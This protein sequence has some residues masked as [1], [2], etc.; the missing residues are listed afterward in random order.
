MTV[1]T[2]LDDSSSW[3]KNCIVGSW[4][5]TKKK[6]KNVKNNNE[7]FSTLLWR[8]LLFLKKIFNPTAV[9]RRIRCLLM[10]PLIIIKK[11]L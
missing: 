5:T 2:L 3:K 9:I 7:Y 11:N 8:S 4:D 1:M 10:I 6:K